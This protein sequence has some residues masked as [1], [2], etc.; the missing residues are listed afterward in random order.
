M[1]HNDKHYVQPTPD[2]QGENLII[3]LTVIGSIITLI[4]SIILTGA[5]IM[6]YSNS[7]QPTT[8]NEP[9]D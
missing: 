7:L 1:Y 4:G 2:A 8:K 9:K 6:A 3:N 5:A